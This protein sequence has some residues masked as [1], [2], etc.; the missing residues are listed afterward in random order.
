MRSQ[1]FVTRVVGEDFQVCMFSTWTPKAIAMIGELPATLADRSIT[2]RMRR[3]SQKETTR[4]LQLHKL[5]ELED[6]RSMAARWAQ[7]R[8]EELRFADPSSLIAS[9]VTASA[10]TGGP[11]WLLPT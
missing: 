11:Y 4:R 5:A 9:H 7:D 1:A 2:I 3:R 6:L 8:M 10:T